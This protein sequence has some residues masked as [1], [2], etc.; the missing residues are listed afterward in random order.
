MEAVDTTPWK[1]PKMQPSGKGNLI[2]NKN[3]QSQQ[4]LEVS[5][6]RKAL[7]VIVDEGENSH[8]QCLTDLVIGLSDVAASTPIT[9]VVHLATDADA[10]RQHLLIEGQQRLACVHFPLPSSRQCMEKLF[11]KLL[12]SPTAPPIVLGSK[13]ASAFTEMY[14]HHDSTTDGFKQVKSLFQCL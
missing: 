13:L 11:K 12:L 4:E 2:Q 6:S 14:L 10:L 3:Q 5:P 1:V 7:V 9:L 8:P